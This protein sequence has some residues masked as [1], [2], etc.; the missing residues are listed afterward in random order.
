MLGLLEAFCQL[1]CGAVYLFPYQPNDAAEVGALVVT[2]S[3]YMT[4]ST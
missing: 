1:N 4:E 2:S 3:L